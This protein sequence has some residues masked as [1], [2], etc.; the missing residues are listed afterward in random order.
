MVTL[1]ELRGAPMLYLANFLS[2]QWSRADNKHQADTEV[3]LIGW[4][5]IYKGANYWYN[6]RG[7]DI[8]KLE[9][10]LRDQ[11]FCI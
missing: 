7:E 11:Y 6:P 2:S 10:S 8:P 5:S 4:Y 3:I 1:S 9:V